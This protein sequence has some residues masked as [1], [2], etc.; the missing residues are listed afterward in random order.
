MS[1]LS[2]TGAGRIHLGLVH[3]VLLVRVH[4]LLVLERQLL[5]HE[6]ASHLLLNCFEDVH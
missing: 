2:V 1:P 5:V 4:A 6:K 3:L